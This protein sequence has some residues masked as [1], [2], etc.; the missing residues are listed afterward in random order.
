MNYQEIIRKHQ[1]ELQHVA[2]GMEKK[3]KLKNEVKAV[4]FDIYGTLF[5]SESGD[6]SEGNYSQSQYQQLKDLLS[7]YSVSL[8]PAEVSTRFKQ[9][10][11]KKHSELKEQGIDYPEVKYPEIWEKIFDWPERQLKEFAVEWE[12]VVN[13]VCPMPHLS[14]I[15]QYLTGQKMV[16]G[17]ISNAQFFTPYLFEAYLGKSLEDLGF[18]SENLFYSYQRNVAKPSI[19]LYQY[20]KE[21]LGFLGIEP[22]QA[23]YIGNDQLKD[24][25]PAQKAGFQTCLFAGDQR[26]LR[27]RKDDQ[28]CENLQSDLVINDLL[29]LKINL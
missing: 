24:I 27:L 3:G 28:R 26:S 18:D 9:E 13:P 2:S 7:R 16:L 23:L 6:I 10:V 15:L 14:E 5:I 19:I 17:I 1:R 25:Y 4:F 8:E 21:R 11:V 29:E 22:Q 12:V 20:A